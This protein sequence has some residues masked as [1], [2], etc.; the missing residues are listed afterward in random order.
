MAQQP[1]NNS[2]QPVYFVAFKKDE[3]EVE[4]MLLK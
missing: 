3:D 2:I 4:I 1:F